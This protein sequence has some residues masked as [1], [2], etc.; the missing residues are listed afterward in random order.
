[1]ENRRF[2]PEQ[3]R[4]HSKAGPKASGTTKAGRSGGGMG[5]SKAGKKAFKSGVSRATHS[6][7]GKNG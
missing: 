3:A 5:K 4:A 1:M 2:T 7:Y 6:K